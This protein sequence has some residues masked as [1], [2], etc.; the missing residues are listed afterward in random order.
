MESRASAGAPAS[1][2]LGLIFL[3]GQQRLTHAQVAEQPQVA[4]FR[5]SKLASIH[6]SGFGPPGWDPG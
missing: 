4:A 5:L 3:A 1:T 6:R 2:A